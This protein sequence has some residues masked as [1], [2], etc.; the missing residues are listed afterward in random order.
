MPL[1]LG[2][3]GEEKGKAENYWYPHYKDRIVNIY[4]PNR[5]REERDARKMLCLSCQLELTFGARIKHFQRCKKTLGKDEPWL[6]GFG[7]IDNEII[8]KR[9]AY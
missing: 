2:L 9:D 5:S 6:R 3:R 4:V 1:E 7:Y 8:N